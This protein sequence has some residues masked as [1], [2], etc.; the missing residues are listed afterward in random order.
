[1]DQKSFMELTLGFPNV[2][3]KE[4]IK[5]CVSNKEAKCKKTLSDYQI[6]AD[7][8]AHGEPLADGHQ[9]PEK[10]LDSRSHSP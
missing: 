10:E 6:M 2:L 9:H 8:T 1:M 4:G 7:D 3:N 5:L